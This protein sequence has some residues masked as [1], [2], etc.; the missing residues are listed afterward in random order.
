MQDSD[1]NVCSVESNEESLLPVALKTW[2]WKI[3]R[4][5][6]VACVETA[7]RTEPRRQSEM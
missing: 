5:G 7:Q 1:R 6:K 3:R 2:H 4:E